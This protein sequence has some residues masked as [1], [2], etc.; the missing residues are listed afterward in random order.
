MPPK[1]RLDVLVGKRVFLEG[2]LIPPEVPGLGVRLLSTTTDDW[3]A[4]PHAK[5]VYETPL[6]ADGS[7][8]NA[9]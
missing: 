4:P 8:L 7:V 6:R 2:Y 3:L 9:V 5:R 1:R